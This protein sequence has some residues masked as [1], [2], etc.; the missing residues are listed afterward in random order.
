MSTTLQMEYQAIACGHCDHHEPGFMICFLLYSTVCFSLETYRYIFLRAKKQNWKSVEK[1]VIYGLEKRKLKGWH[2]T[3]HS[4]TAQVRSTRITCQ[5]LWFCFCLNA[6]HVVPQLRH[7][8]VLLCIGFQWRPTLENFF[9]KKRTD[10]LFRNL[11]SRGKF[12]PSSCSVT[13]PLQNNE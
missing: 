4:I 11:S 12:L 9:E 10:P 3:T 7:F 5:Y 6:V 2:S 13:P 8:F 1:L